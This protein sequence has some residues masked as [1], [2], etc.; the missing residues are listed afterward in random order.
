MSDHAEE[1]QEAI[2]DVHFEAVRTAKE[3]HEDAYNGLALEAEHILRSCGT[4]LWP[5]IRALPE[6]LSTKTAIHFPHVYDPPR[7]MKCNAR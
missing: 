6:R 3:N 2:E 4:Q 7:K 1:N 5:L